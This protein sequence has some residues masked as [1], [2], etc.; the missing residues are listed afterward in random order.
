MGAEKGEKLTPLQRAYHELW[1]KQKKALQKKC[2]Q[3]KGDLTREDIMHLRCI[4]CNKVFSVED[5]LNS[6]T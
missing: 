6:T 3:C 4:T 1:L 2:P 5:L